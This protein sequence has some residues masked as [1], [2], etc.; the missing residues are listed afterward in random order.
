MRTFLL[1]LAL[2][3]S[4]A[5]VATVLVV[6]PF[7][8]TGTYPDFWTANLQAISGDTIEVRPMTPNIIGQLIVDQ[9]LT[10]TGPGFWLGQNY[11]TYFSP[12]YRGWEIREVRVQG[13]AKLVLNSVFVEQD[14]IVEADSRLNFNKSR[15]S[16]IYSGNNSTIE[17]DRS[18][19]NSL[20]FDRCSGT[21]S[22]NSYNVSVYGINSFIANFYS[23]A[24][25]FFALSLVN[26]IV[27]DFSSNARYGELTNCII[28]P[29]SSPLQNACTSNLRS[30]KYSAIP[31]TPG[32]G[33]CDITNT[34]YGGGPSTV[35]ANRCN[36]NSCDSSFYLIPNSPAIGA[37]YN[38]VDCGI[39]GGPTPYELSGLPSRP[40]IYELMAPPATTGGS[41]P[42]PVVVKV[43]AID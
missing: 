41:G 9:D 31:Q 12:G 29:A 34:S 32:S 28:L 24:T 5:A 17:F 3:A 37:G 11:P 33:G 42:M 26:C 27:G 18:H 23:N 40:W 35:Y 43:K 1:V 6:D 14:I 15:C 10:I 22:C 2:W 16:K 13:G 19:I 7:G 20:W 36:T 38:G 25:R 4:H 8:G 39:F 30:V 21:S